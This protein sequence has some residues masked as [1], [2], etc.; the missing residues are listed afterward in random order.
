MRTKTKA[1]SLAVAAAMTFAAAPASAAFVNTWDY[2]VSLEWITAGPD[3]PTFTSG[4]GFQEVTSERLSW[5]SA[6]GSVDPSVNPNRSGLQI[7]DTPANGAINTGDSVTTV[8]ITHFN[9]EISAN[10]ATLNT[11]T[12]LT[13]LILTPLDPPVTGGASLPPLSL[14]FATTFTETPNVANC[15][16]PVVNNCD[17]IFIVNFEALQQTFTLE[18]VTYNTSVVADGLGFLDDATCAAAG[19]GPGCFGLT[20]PEFEF[21]TVNFGFGISAA[22]VPNPAML[23]LFGTG[24]L[25]LGAVARRRRQS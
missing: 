9:S 17:D 25:A 21:T 11:A 12:L 24:L 20:T 5:G 18:G 16:F 10:F 15:G 8:G 2:T 7:I 4:T 19:E 23:A 1:V 13:N 14:Q 3:A 6:S 22:Q